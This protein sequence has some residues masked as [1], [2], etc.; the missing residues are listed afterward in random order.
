MIK[1]IKGL[2]PKAGNY[3]QLLLRNVQNNK[4]HLLLNSCKKKNPEEKMKIAIKK[5][6]S[7]KRKVFR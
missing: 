5:R 6:K 4:Y 3:F 7:I 2:K 1:N